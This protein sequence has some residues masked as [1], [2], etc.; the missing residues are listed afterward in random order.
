MPQNTRF[1]ILYF[2][3]TSLQPYL[4]S[5][6]NGEEL[7]GWNTAI[8]MKETITIIFV[9]T[10]IFYFCCPGIWL[11]LRHGNIEKHTLTA[12]HCSQGYSHARSHL[13]PHIAMMVLLLTFLRQGDVSVYGPSVR[14]LWGTVYWYHVCSYL[15]FGTKFNSKH[16]LVKKGEKKDV[17]VFRLH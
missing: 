9:L 5:S 17:N 8:A 15:L 6:N 2:S 13:L 10:V 14:K 3:F 7:W 16:S 1:S 12:I 4:L 11:H